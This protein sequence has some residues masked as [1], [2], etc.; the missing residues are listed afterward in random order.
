MLSVQLPA[1]P[2]P[3]MNHDSERSGRGAHLVVQV[4]VQI[5]AHEQ[6]QQ[7]LLAILVMLQ[8]GSAMEAKQLA[9]QST[10]ISLSNC[11]N[12]S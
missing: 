7:G 10:D 9:A 1:A 5:V 2:Q 11:K 3:Y 6:V 12:A 8:H 4:V